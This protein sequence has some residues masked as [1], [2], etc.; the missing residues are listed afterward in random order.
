MNKLLSVF[1]Q[2]PAYEVAPLL[3]GCILEREIDGKKMRVRI[4]ETEAYDETDA[5]SH[6]YKG[7]T[8]R[9]EIMFGEAG[10]LYVYFTYGMH[11]C[12]N[13]VTGKKG[14]GSAVLIRA[15]EPVEGEECMRE[16]RNVEGIQ[17]TNGPAKLCKALAIDKRLNGHDLT[18][19][20]LKLIIQKPAEASKII[21]TKRVGI[22]HAKDI[23]WR[24]YLSGNRYVSKL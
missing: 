22:S 13:V 12:C 2:K 20:P 24:F 7:Q 17:L 9:T 8:S 18:E 1:L 14:D 23:L 5:A 10:Y 6:S 3:L 11:Y 21:Q 15:V 16:L 4:V 19:A